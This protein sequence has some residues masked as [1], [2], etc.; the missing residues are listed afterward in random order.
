MFQKA[1][2][3]LPLHTSLVSSFCLSHCRHI[4]LP[5]DSNMPNSLHLRTFEYV[6]LC[7]DYSLPCFPMDGSYAFFKP[8]FDFFRE[9]F[10]NLQ[11]KHCSLFVLVIEVSVCDY[12]FVYMLNFIF[13]T[14]KNK[15]HERRNYVC[16]IHQYI[17]I[18]LAQYVT[19]SRCFI[20]IFGI[21]KEDFFFL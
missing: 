3:N 11:S 15:L 7:L 19:S 18:G 1:L 2:H 21:N 6:I 8:K 16:L 4:G 13:I 12:K 5:P 9:V 20:Y 17:F 10:P 14:I